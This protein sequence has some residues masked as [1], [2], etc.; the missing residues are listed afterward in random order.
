VSLPSQW[1]RVHRATEQSLGRASRPGS[2]RP[3]EAALTTEPGEAPQ[4]R[5]RRLGYGGGVGW[6]SQQSM[7]LSLEEAQQLVK[8]LGS[9]PSAVETDVADTTP[10]ISLVEYRARR[11]T[12]RP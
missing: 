2:D 8:L 9:V 4:V 11:Q 10:P 5:I 6:Y 1:Y 12:T 3:L 7:D